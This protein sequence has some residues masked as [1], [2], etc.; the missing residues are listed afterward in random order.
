M[1]T[2]TLKMAMFVFCG[3]LMGIASAFAKSQTEV[4]Q[5]TRLDMA[6][7]QVLMPADAVAH[8]Q[9]NYKGIVASP[10]N[11]PEG[12][13]ESID[14]NDALLNADFENV[15]RINDDM[16]QNLRG[17]IASENPSPEPIRIIIASENPT[18]PPVCNGGICSN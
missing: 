4:S 2:N 18:P 8:E 6:V 10:N 13:K 5:Q 15:K 12:D 7:D 1:K 9:G 17:I 14:L 3:L 16:R 11:S